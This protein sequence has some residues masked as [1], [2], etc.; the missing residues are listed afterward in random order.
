MS[1]IL[2]HSKRLFPRGNFDCLFELPQHEVS[3][4]IA[5]SP[6]GDVQETDAEVVVT[7]DLPDVTEESL[8]VRVDEKVLT[9]KAER[10]LEKENQ[11]GGFLHQE[12]AYG[13]FHRSFELP[14]SIDTDKINARYDRGV[15]RIVLPKQPDKQKV[16]RRIDVH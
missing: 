13:A 14:K 1:L 11:D 8:D 3:G 16:S 7:A 12:R 10:Q 15:L 2:R 9:L 5:W 6:A 4:V